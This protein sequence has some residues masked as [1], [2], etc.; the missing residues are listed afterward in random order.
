MASLL[1][2]LRR[3]P[4]PVEAWFDRVI[5]VSFAFPEETLRPLVPKALEIDAFQGL[6]FVTV[7]LVWTKNLRPAGF[8][9]ALGQDFFLAGYR[10]FTRL[11]DGGRRLRGLHILRSETDQRRMV[12]SGNLLTHYRYRHVHVRI[13]ES[14]SGDT[15]VMLKRPDGGTTLDLSIADSGEKTPL[16]TGLPFPDWPSAR[17]FAGPMPFTF[18]EESDSR[19]VVIEGRREDWKPRPVAVTAWRVALFDETPLRDVEPVLAN[20]FAVNAVP[21][22]WSRGRV[23]HAGDR[24]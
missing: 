12:W 16:P 2:I 7:A 1:K 10:I 18:S 4:F 8:P 6:G 11:N 23:V 22:R 17:R 9:A 21:Y 20:A 13:D 24:P 15:R 14:G 3:H 5:A 19:F